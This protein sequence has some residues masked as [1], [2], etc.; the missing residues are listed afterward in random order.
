MQKITLLQCSCNFTVFQVMLRNSLMQ[1]Q[2]NDIRLQFKQACN[3]IGPMK[4]LKLTMSVSI[5]HS[6]I[7]LTPVLTFNWHFVFG[8]VK[9]DWLLILT[10]QTT[11]NVHYF[12]FVVLV[13]AINSLPYTAAM[14]VIIVKNTIK[15]FTFFFSV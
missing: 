11:F 1:L 10:F 6:A 5:S 15:S 4:R 13:L 9:C 2:F 7:C 3:V 12:F 14:M 8:A